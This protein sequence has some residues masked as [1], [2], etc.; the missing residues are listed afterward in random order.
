MHKGSLIIWF[1]LFFVK[2]FGGGV[3]GDWKSALVSCLGV[4][5]RE[6]VLENDSSLLSES[7]SSS[8]PSE[9]AAIPSQMIQAVSL[10][11]LKMSMSSFSI[12]GSVEHRTQLCYFKVGSFSCLWLQGS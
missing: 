1:F 5:P 9:V 8:G 12:T 10:F 6:R 4:S 2:T 7:I 11:L 3:G